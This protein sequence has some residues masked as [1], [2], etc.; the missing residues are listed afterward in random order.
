MTR[1]DAP[2]A[3]AHWHKLG[4]QLRLAL[5][6]DEPR[7]I[8]AYLHAGEHLI[9]PH[10]E[11]PWPVH[12]RMLRLLLATA[13]DTLL[14]FAWRLTCLDACCRPLGALGKLVSDDASA[15]RLRELSQRLASFSCNP[16]D[17]EHT[18]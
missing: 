14:P 7:L 5:H 6:P 17:A 18:P 3:L 8:A 12:D 10:G 11:P 1:V 15:R 16:S 9:A 2:A 4:M 13:G